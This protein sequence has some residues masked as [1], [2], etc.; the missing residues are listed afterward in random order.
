MEISPAFLLGW[1]G[2][3]K[4]ML[5]K[6]LPEASTGIEPVGQPTDP[7][8]RE[9]WPWWKLKRWAL[10]TSAQVFHSCMRRKAKIIEVGR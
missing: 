4:Q 9:K 1:W 6:K 10:T 3:I 2:L 5:D 8:E 7:E